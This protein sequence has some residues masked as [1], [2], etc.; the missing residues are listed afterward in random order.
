[1]P[2]DDEGVP[3]KKRAL[4]EQG[5]VKD[6]LYNREVAAL[7]KIDSDGFCIRSDFSSKPTIGRSN[8]SIKTGKCKNILE[9][10]DK[11]VN[12]ISLHGMHTA[13]QIS[14]DFG[15]EV[16]I[17]TL[18]EEG[19]KTPVKGFILSGN[20]FELF[21]NVSEIGSKLYRSDDMAA[22]L[23]AFDNVSVVS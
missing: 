15:L 3:S 9:Q 18:V 11:Y 23:I 4:V 13:N 7:E 1:R 14:G 17:A 8:L 10:L 22:P 6:F 2:F 21:N 20:I 16:N 5:V 12:I 19:K